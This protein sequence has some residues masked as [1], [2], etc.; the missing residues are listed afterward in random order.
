MSRPLM[1]YDGDCD[2]CR[3]WLARWRRVTGEAVEYAAY[4]DVASRHPEIPIERF[5]AAVHLREPDGTWTHG[6]EAV[7]RTLAYAKGHGKWRWLY[8]H[9]PPFA[10][11]SEWSYEIIARHR[12][13]FFRITKWLWGAHVVPPGNALTTWIFLRLLGI[14]YVAAFASLAVQVIGLIG[15]QGILPVRD[16]LPLVR[17]QIGPVRGLWF[18]PSVLWLAHGDGAL[19]ALCGVGLAASVLLAIGVAPLLCALVAWISYLSLATV[20]RDFLWFQ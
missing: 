2:F 20:A 16:Y 5:R 1:V 17:E 13:F 4:Q 9:G 11:A 15:A 18:T 12:P 6:A 8:E 7:F 19:R 3:V 14:V 10:W